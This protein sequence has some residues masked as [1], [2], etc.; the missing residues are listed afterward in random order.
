MLK[1]YLLQNWVLI[2]ILLAFAI[3]LK[4]TVFMEKKVI[5]RM[6]VL[7]GAIFLLSF[8]VFTEF[9]LA[10]LGEG[11]DVRVILMAI[12]YSTTPFILA[13]VIFTLIKKQHWSI[14]I[15]AI[16]LAVLDIIS[17]F[18][19]IVFSLNE[20]GSLHRGPLGLL[21]FI[22]VGLYCAFLIF[23]LL[24]HSNK[25]A[26]EVVPIIFLCFAFV[27]GLI[28]PFV[29]GNDFAHI[30]CATVA[31]ALYA[32]YVFL[33][34]QLTKKDALTGLLNRQAY[35]AEVVNDPENVTAM[36]SIDM[37]GLKP[38]NDL[39]GHAAGDEALVT[40]S[41]CFIR[42]LKRK[43]S[44]YRVGGD[45]FV[46]VCRQNTREEVLELVERIRKNV[47]E[48]KYHCAIGYGFNED[49]SKSID[50]LLK[51]S[52]DMMYAEKARFYAESGNDR[53]KV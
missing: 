1:G 39:E 21:P 15:P 3:S 14:F 38:I 16:A 13:Q 34:L 11:K 52:D 7:I 50:A 23:I 28:L 43:Q 45:E 26:M 25:R 36:L 32:Y 18:T 20:D 49:G 40:L 9:Y 44:G 47:A 12:R 5:R 4:E 24:K 51:E 19:G 41:L 31:M 2:L 42:A 10:D 17:I 27:S 33:I 29:F 8:V 30:F 35:Y 22:M 37:N 48:T 53:R 46:I 6:Y